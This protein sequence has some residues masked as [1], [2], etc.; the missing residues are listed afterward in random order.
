M[1]I[2][3]WWNKLDDWF[4]DLGISYQ[5]TLYHPTHRHVFCIALGIVSINFRWK[6][7]K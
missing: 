2:E 5:R 1:K 6:K 7:I 3:I 4:F